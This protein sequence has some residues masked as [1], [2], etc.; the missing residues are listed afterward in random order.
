MC[1]LINMPTAF[2]GGFHY[3]PCFA[4]WK[5]SPMEGSHLLQE[6]HLGLLSRSVWL[7]HSQLLCRH[8][9]SSIPPPAPQQ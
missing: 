9:S 4:G 3:D 1:C 2:W 6:A 8:S 5:R 7:P